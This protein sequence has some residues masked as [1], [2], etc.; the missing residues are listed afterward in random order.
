MI[1][2]ALVQYYNRLK[3]E[4]DID[5]P[6]FGYSKEKISFSIV[7]N[8]EGKLL[9]IKDI[10]NKNNKGKLI[11]QTLS[12]P[13][14]KGRSGKHPPPYFLWDNSKYVLGLDKTGIIQ[15]R[16]DAFKDLINK[17]ESDDVGIKAVKNFLNQWSPENSKSINNIQDII[18]DTGNIVFEL[19]S[20][21]GYVYNRENV[22]KVWEKLI[23]VQCDENKKSICLI[24]GK[25]APIAPTHP[26]IKNV[27]GAQ[28]AGA[29]II[30]F[31]KNSFESYAKKQNYNSPMGEKS[32]FDYTTA[33][34]YLLANKSQRI[35]IG[36]ASTVF[37]TEKK[38]PIESI[39]GK[40]LEQKDDG[41][42]DSIKNFLIAVK[43][44]KMPEDI[45]SNVKFYILGLS[46]NAARIS[47]RF[48][49]VSNV[50]TISKNIGKHFNDLEII[51]SKDADPTFPGMWKILIETAIRHESKNIPPLLAGAVFKAIIS[52]TS[53]PE[54]LL[55]ILIQRI[56][57]VEKRSI[58]GKDTVVENINYIR[59]GMLKAILNRKTR[60]NKL[61]KK[62]VTMA[63]DKENKEPAYLLGRLFAVL[64]KVQKDAIPNANATIKDRYFGA[65]S[66]TPK[67]V[68]PQL[69]RM[70]QN[71][72]AKTKKEKPA[73]AINSDKQ[74]G[75]I[76]QNIN[77]FP[78]HLSLNDQGLFAIGYYHQRQDIYT[79][80]NNKESL[81]ENTGE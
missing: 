36:D 54:S 19:D 1:L 33:L 9:Q 45:D 74:I 16:F 32:A 43:N 31:N 76:F 41:F 2:Q 21:I 72:I 37:W 62:E 3:A 23:N 34:N 12:V 56:K 67:I 50:G 46:P 58:N 24:E 49:N 17:I 78:A 8:E 29:A 40:L 6:E 81:T 11:P 27:Y 71:H 5:I 65:A 39:F 57:A 68:F 10:R 30:S 35:S 13:K 75:E 4:P 69:L 47:I 38:S 52:G 25:N 79:K 20:E 14:L 64:E 18:N 66:A 53:Y 80:K 28:S 60:L 70:S 15:D 59:A 73:W 26:L 61:N 51:K 7:I 48:W 44:G 55:T 42:D 77:E 22:K 63:L